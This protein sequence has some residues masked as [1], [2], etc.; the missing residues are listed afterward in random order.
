MNNLQSHIIRTIFKSLDNNP[1]NIDGWFHLYPVGTARNL[2]IGKEDVR[3]VSADCRRFKLDAERVV[4]VVHCFHGHV[5][6]ALI[7]QSN[8]H[9]TCTVN[10]TGMRVTAT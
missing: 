2:L 10:K 7:R 4:A 1:S 8:R 3:R 9:V 5:Q 6:S